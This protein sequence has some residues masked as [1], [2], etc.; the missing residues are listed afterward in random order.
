MLILKT[1]VINAGPKRKGVNAQLARSAL[2]GAESVGADVE[3]IDLYKLDLHGC[4]TCLI[5]KKEGMAGKCYWRDDVS[6]L[7]ERI[8]NADAL[9]IS[10]PIFF[11]NPTS[12]YMA[13][14]ERL[15]YCL[16][17]YDV[18]NSF[19]GKVNVGLFYIINY[20][21]DYFEKSIRPQLKQSE[22]LLKMLNGRV[23]IDTFSNITQNDY[24]DKSQKGIDSLKLKEEQLRVDL[25]KIFKIGADLSG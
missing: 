10:A 9:L 2:E 8:L 21:E 6:S 17:S 7:I 12:H 3:Y 11:S 19:N 4:M 14:L 23:V 13:L 1:I 24:S 20:P 16:V 25:E 5:C 15:I 22:D 18:G